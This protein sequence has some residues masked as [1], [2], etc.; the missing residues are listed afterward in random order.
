MQ[1]SESVSKVALWTGRILSALSALTL[2]VFGLI[3]LL[4]QKEALPPFLKYGYPASAFVPIIVVEIACGVIYAIPPTSVFGA[5]LITGYLG[6]A[7][8]THV[9]AGE[10]PVMAIA[11]AVVAWLGI[12]LREPRL[13]A[14]T[15]FR[16]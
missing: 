12:W 4:N 9:R 5:I 7:T 8:S 14:L 15:P 3:G 16:K 6:G 13:R 11:V 2:I 1:N 10:P